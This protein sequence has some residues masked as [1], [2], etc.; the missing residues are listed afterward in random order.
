MTL[1][2]TILFVSCPTELFFLFHWLTAQAL[3]IARLSP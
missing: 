1:D 2:S 3:D